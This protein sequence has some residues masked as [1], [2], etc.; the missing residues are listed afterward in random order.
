[1]KQHHFYLVNTNSKKLKI[2]NFLVGMLK[3][4]YGQSGLWTVK[5]IVS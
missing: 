2:E 1:M 3:N 4:G 5:L